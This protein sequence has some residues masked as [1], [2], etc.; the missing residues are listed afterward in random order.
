MEGVRMMPICHHFP[1][2]FSTSSWGVLLPFFA[3]NERYL[4][5]PPLITMGKNAGIMFVNNTRIENRAT[6][7]NLAP[8]QKRRTLDTNLRDESHGNWWNNFPTTDGH[9]VLQEVREGQK[10]ARLNSKLPRDLLRLPKCATRSVHLHSYSRHGFANNYDIDLQWLLSISLRQSVNVTIATASIV[11]LISENSG[12]TPIDDKCRIA[13]FPFW[14]ILNA[15]SDIRCAVRQSEFSLQSRMRKLRPSA[16]KK[17]KRFRKRN[18][19]PSGI[20]TKI[21]NSH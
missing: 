18:V 11:A 12:R 10:M 16:K 3:D 8:A 17:A 2:P 19:A 13:D 5:W 6:C 7:V 21:A 9:K 4:I 15:I 1:L 20:A 14:R